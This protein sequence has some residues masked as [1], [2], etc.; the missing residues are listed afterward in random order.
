MTVFISKE[1][2]FCAAHK[3]YNTKWSEEKNEEVFGKCANTN[4]HGHNFDMTVTVKG[5]PDPDTGFIINFKILK[6]IIKK[7]IIEKVDHK[8]LDMDVEFL[9]GKMTSCENLVIAFWDILKPKI[10]EAS[11]GRATLHY[12]KLY[13]TPT[14]F[15]EYYG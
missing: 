15:A 4:W 12:I 8:N 1:V 2:H 10:D 5:E 9:N 11:G 3:L 6:K 14:S 13:E 7:E